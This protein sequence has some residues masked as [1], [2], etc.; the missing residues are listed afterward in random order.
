MEQIEQ[1]IQ[2]LISGLS[3]FGELETYQG[4]R[5]PTVPRPELAPEIE[6]FLHT[7]PFLRQ[8]ES[9]VTYLECYAGACAARFESS[10]WIEIFG[11]EH[12]IALHIVDGEGDVV[13]EDGFLVFS[14]IALGDDPQGHLIEDAFAFDATGK[15]RRGIYWKKSDE[16]DYTWLC[17]TFQGWL[18]KVL[19]KE[20][21]RWSRA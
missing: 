19:N 12:N 15:R 20:L 11:F 2:A 13:D 3:A 14:L 17:E 18:E 10:F 9:Y 21:L 1:T 16:P 8:D 7:Y 6:Q 4:P 5:H